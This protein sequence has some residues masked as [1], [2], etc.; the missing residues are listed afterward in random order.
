MASK[1]TTQ[2]LHYGDICELSRCFNESANLGIG[3]HYRINEALKDLLARAHAAHP[4]E[5]V[6]LHKAVASK[7]PPKA[8]QAKD[9]RKEK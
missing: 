9:E 4:H 7:R 2:D 1:G 8:E 5:V 6:R 3:T